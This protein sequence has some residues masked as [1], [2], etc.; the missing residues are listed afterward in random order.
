MKCNVEGCEYKVN[1]Y[2]GKHVRDHICHYSDPRKIEAISPSG[3]S[4]SR[5]SG[6]WLA[7]GQGRKNRKSAIRRFCVAHPETARRVTVPGEI[8]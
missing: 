2:T 5:S 1:G 6:G 4:P 3:G 8:V 7:P